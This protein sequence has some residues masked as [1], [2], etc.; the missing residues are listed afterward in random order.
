M[1][2]PPGNRKRT[3][4]GPTY[5]I[6]VEHPGL[7]RSRRI[8]GKNEY[9]VQMKAAEQLRVWDNMWE[10][11]LA[12]NERTRQR[13]ARQNERIARQEDRQNK[14]RLAQER[15]EEAEPAV[16]SL[17]GI[18]VHALGIDHRIHWEDLKD[19]SS[20]PKREPTLLPAPVPPEPQEPVL[21]SEPHESL[22]RPS[23]GVL[24][25]LFSV[26][27]QKK[28]REAASLFQ[29]AHAAWENKRAELTA[30]ARTAYESAVKAWAAERDAYVTA[31]E[32]SN[33]RIDRWRQEYEAAKPEAVIGYCNLVLSRSEYPL[34]FPRDFA[35]DYNPDSRILLVDYHL[36]TPSHIPTVKKVRYE[37][38][39]DGFTETHL[40]PGVI[41]ELYA[42]VVYQI[43]LRTIH[44][45]YDADTTPCLDVIVFN[46][47]VRDGRVGGEVTA[48]ILSVRAERTAFRNL[49]LTS[50]ELKTCFRRLKGKGFAALHLMTPV[51]PI[52][53]TSREDGRF[54]ASSPVPRKQRSPRRSS[55]SPKVDPH[56]PHC[57]HEFDP[58]PARKKKCPACDQYVP[59]RTRPGGQRVLCTLDQV[60]EI[61]RQWAEYHARG[62]R[63]GDE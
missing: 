48:C 35:L 54:V 56:C 45:L 53:S 19:R 3:S 20:F 39:R 51:A 28:C 47:W 27:R 44:E 8:T 55:P 62:A 24:D 60:K 4:A 46:G 15:T 7:G 43:A 40:A 17:Q 5:Y 11:R 13:I 6:D 10:T 21:P 42:N 14:L 1:A 36:P 57:G 29:E 38:S 63:N 16:A 34:H 25:S 9:V 52:L 37:Q 26:R 18:L 59:A 49:D 23:L 33:V 31:Q 41:A 2:K 61:E 50:E 58:I 32:E 12:A 30:A 22:F